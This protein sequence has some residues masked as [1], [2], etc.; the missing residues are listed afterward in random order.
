MDE[1][2]GEWERV[3]VDEEEPGWVV[4]TYMLVR[5]GKVNIPV[6]VGKVLA[7]LE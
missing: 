5:G 2:F 6:E 3:K 1:V 7:V 4:P